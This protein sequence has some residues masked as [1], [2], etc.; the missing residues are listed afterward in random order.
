MSGRTPAH[1]ENGCLVYRAASK[2][3]EKENAMLH[4]VAH[5]MKEASEKNDEQGFTLIKLLVVTL[6]PLHK[7]TCLPGSRPN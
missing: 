3:R 6:L 5:K 2:S 1:K 7:R 4:W